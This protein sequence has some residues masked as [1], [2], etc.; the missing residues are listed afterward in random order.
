VVS[1]CTEAAL[2]PFAT[3]AE[4]REFADSQLSL[5]ALPITL[6]QLANEV[7]WRRLGR[8]RRLSGKSAARKTSNM[9]SNISSDRPL[10]P[11]CKSFDSLAKFPG[12]TLSERAIDALRARHFTILRDIADNHTDDTWTF[13]FFRLPSVDP[14][15]RDLPRPRIEHETRRLSGPLV[16]EGHACMIAAI[17]DELV[18]R[19][20]DR[21]DR[22]TLLEIEDR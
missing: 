18:A 6:A 12:T 22:C 7:A 1:G 5:P 14:L 4:V 15:T 3:E 16:Q 8:S 20:G 11:H 21:R 9:P 10:G 17:H 13:A 19:H 2:G